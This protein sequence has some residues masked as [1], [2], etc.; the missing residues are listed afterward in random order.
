MAR[1]VA[2]TEVV[3][4]E[5]VL[6]PVVELGP[7]DPVHAAAPT[8]AAITANLEKA[9]IRRCVRGRSIRTRV[10][11]TAPPG[12]QGPVSTARKSL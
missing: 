9:G 7:E 10:A 11:G 12:N 4:D 3:V 5:P 8:R 6:S 2:T 1:V